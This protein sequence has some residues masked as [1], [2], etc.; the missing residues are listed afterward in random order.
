VN[1]Q[2]LESLRTE[3]LA[4]LKRVRL[5]HHLTTV[6]EVAA[7]VSMGMLMAWIVIRVWG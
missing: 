7:L 2:D 6:A 4:G 1:S 5:I 3:S